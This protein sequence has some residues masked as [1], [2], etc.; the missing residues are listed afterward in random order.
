MDVSGTATIVRGAGKNLPQTE[1][2]GY[3]S[4]GAIELV[5]REISRLCTP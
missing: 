5:T 2:I 4:S 3:Q 1:I